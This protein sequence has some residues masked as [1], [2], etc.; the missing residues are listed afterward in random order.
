MKT[1][2][3]VPTFHHDSQL[4]FDD[5]EVSDYAEGRIL[6]ESVDKSDVWNL[7]KCKAFLMRRWAVSAQYVAIYREDLK[8]SWPEI[9]E[10]DSAVVLHSVIQVK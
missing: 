10:T 3:R 8:L 5:Q 9:T 1:I 6:H 2:E 7:V 4:A